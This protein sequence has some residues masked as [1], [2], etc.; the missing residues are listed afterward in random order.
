MDQPFH[1]R[2]DKFVGIDK[3]D[4]LTSTA[5][6]AAEF[7]ASRLQWEHKEAGHPV[8]F[9]RAEGF[10][11]CLQRRELPSHPYWV[12]DRPEKMATLRVGQFLLLDLRLQ[13]A[14]VSRG[15]VDCVSIYTSVDALEQFQVEHDMRSSTTL[16][17]PLGAALSDPVIRSL[18]EAMV[19]VL[20][21]KFS[22]S[23]LLV[24][25]VALATLAHLSANYTLDTRMA[26]RRGGLA[27]WQERRAKEMLLG[28]MDGQI[29]L[30]ALAAECRLSRSHFAR[31]FKVSTGH[32]PLRW[33][34]MQRIVQAKAL[35]LNTS[36]TLERIAAAC[37]FSDAS[38]LVRSFTAA[39]GV[40]PGLWRRA[41]R[42]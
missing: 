21:G 42:S 33:L 24:D 17:A 11:L 27:P 39:T 2:F 15:S 41:K 32:T 23:Q 3:P 12:E 4:T 16:R 31:A 35:L 26:F 6:E 5:F 20:E 7:T 1:S 8:K 29:G 22:A 34:Q 30:E 36:F 19:P 40:S 28:H 9:D 38:H 10:M 25:H 18:G 37:G 13:H 14:S